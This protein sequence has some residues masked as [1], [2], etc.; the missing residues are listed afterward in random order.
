M[1]NKARALIFACLITCFDIYYGEICFYPYHGELYALFFR[2]FQVIV[3]MVF[4]FIICYFVMIIFDYI[5]KRIR[6]K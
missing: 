2:L 6:K 4:Y 5:Y 1:N 3:H